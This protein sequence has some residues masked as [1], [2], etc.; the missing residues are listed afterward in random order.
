MKAL[1]I[2]FL[3]TALCVTTVCAANL[4]GR[5]KALLSGARSCLGDRYDAA[6]YRGGPPP[7]GRGACTDVLY[8]A[9][10]RTGVNLQDEV[11]R[12]IR[13]S[14]RLYPAKGD[15]NIDYRRCVNLIVWFKGFA[16]SHTLRRDTKMLVQWQPGDVV[17]WS[18]S[19]DHG[20]DHCGII[21]DRKNAKGVPLV[22]HNLGPTCVE[23]DV[24]RN[25]EAI[26]HFRY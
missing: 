6:Y 17:F 26:G 7:K 21:S 8:Y 15:R 22:I 12:D 10:L 5:Q 9:F 3:V 25:W 11:D 23:N 2:V 14:P 13:S 20:A 19:D 24:L 4:T 1:M 18:W 16:K